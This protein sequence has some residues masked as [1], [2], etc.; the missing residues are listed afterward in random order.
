MASILRQ[1]PET[2]ATVASTELN[3]L[4]TSPNGATG[5]VYDNSASGERWTEGLLEL[6][7]DFVSAP[8]AGAIVDVY[9]TVAPD[10]TNY[11]DANV[12]QA[13]ALRVGEFVVSNTTAA[14]RCHCSIRLFP[15]KT[16][17]FFVNRSGQAFP[18]T[19]STIVLFP[20]TTE[21]A[22]A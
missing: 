17:F 16:K 11:G 9:A 4:G 2:G 10:G 21:V 19:G 6:N 22:A 20:Y 14:Q 5:A 1:F 3:S 13:T 7:V 18:A 12:N 15:Y 8:T